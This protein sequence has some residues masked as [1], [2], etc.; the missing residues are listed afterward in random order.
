MAETWEIRI[1]MGDEMTGRTKRALTDT[2]RIM[3][4]IDDVIVDCDGLNPH[5][6]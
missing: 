3:D 5:L 2:I 1:L 4:E 6:I